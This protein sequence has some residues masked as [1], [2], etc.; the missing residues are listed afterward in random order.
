MNDQQML[1][2][3]QVKIKENAPNFEVRFKDQSTFMKILGKL[4]FF[5]KRFMTN[6]I[7]VI[8]TKVY[9]PTKERFEQYPLGSFL[10]L[11]HEYVHIMDYKRNPVQF[12][13]G[14]LFPQIKAILALLAVLAVVSPWFLLALLFLLALAPW[15]APFRKK[16]EMRGFGMS[17]K[18]RSWLGWEITEDRMNH[19]VEQFTSSAYYFMWPFSKLVR[20]ELTEWADPNN[21]EC[22]NDS[23]P[24]YK[25]T[26]D[27]IKA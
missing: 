2:A 7:T 9:W 19:Y 16:T 14:Y 20:K 1:D 27:I 15:P 24:A 10:T 25:D 26:Y 22:L 21:L 4:L 23:N 11:A 12:V 3:L 18:A 13:L 17:I 6:Y 5:N 8:G